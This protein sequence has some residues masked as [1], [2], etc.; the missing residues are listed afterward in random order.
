MK[1]RACDKPLSP[2]EIV[3]IEGEDHEMWPT[4]GRYE[5]LCGKCKSVAFSLVRGD[6]DAVYGT[7]SFDG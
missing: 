4:F 5:E 7:R 1:C 3:W 6:Y 2:S